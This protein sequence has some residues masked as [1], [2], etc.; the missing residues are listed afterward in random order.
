V[1]PT[2]GKQGSLTKLLKG[3]EANIWG[4]SLANAWGQ[5]LPHGLGTTHPLAKQVK[6]TVPFF[7]IEKSQGPQ[8]P[9]VTYANFKC[10]IRPQK[11]ETHRVHMTAG[12]DKLDYPG[13]ASS[14]AV[15]ML[16]TKININN[17]FLMSPAMAPVTLA[18]TSRSSTLGPR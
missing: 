13:D 17:P 1:P 4:H 6:G 5:L 2:A 11:T 8:D 3:P 18:L 10:N 14:P 15:S 12:R 9:K 7:F 16:D